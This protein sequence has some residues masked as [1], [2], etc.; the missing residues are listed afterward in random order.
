MG[1]RIGVGAGAKTGAAPLLWLQDEKIRWL[2][3]CF[4]LRPILWQV[5]L[6]NLY[7]VY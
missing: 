2:C 1:L 7:T 3:Y 6:K 4:Q 5:K